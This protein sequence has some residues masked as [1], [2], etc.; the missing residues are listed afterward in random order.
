MLPR[1]GDMVWVSFQNGNVE[2]PLWE[3]YVYLPS[4]QPPSEAEKDVRVIKTRS[5][6]K[7]VFDDTE[8]RLSITVEDALGNSCVMNE[9][10]IVVEDKFGNKVEMGADFGAVSGTPGIKINGAS[11][12]VMEAMVN[13]IGSQLQFVGNLGAPTPI[14]PTSKVLLI[15][16]SIPGGDILSNKVKGL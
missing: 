16:R 9:D 2:V 12:I 1:I 10:G 13:F 7:I 8:D 11:R 14:F 3:G 15:N 6:H 5:G 4:S